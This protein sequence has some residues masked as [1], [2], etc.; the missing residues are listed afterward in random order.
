MK[1]LIVQKVD[2]NP[3][4]VFDAALVDDA[5]VEDKTRRLVRDHNARSCVQA[6]GALIWSVDGEPRMFEFFADDPMLRP[7][8]HAQVENLHGVYETHDGR[9][10]KFYGKCVWHTWRTNAYWEVRIFHYDKQFKYDGVLDSK[11]ILAVLRGPHLHGIV[12]DKE[13]MLALV[14]DVVGQKIETT[15]FS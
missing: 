14:R 6:E 8:Q 2:T 11:D 13:T 5:R 4:I 7:H 1:V 12:D 15:F 10:F 3:L 9:K